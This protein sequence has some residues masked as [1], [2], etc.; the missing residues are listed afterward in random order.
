MIISSKI[1][2]DAVQNYQ[3]HKEKQ[4]SVGD[5]ISEGSL[6]AF[7]IAML[8]FAVIFFVMEIILIFYAIMIAF[9]CTEGGPERIIHVFLAVFFTIPYTLLMVI[10]NKC[11]GQTLRSGGGWAVVPSSEVN[12][13]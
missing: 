9:S 6:Y 1:L 12:S 4:A 11:A 8:I 2:S 10:F 5:S 3:K 13:E 7:H